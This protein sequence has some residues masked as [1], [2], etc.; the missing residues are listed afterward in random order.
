MRRACRER[1]SRHRIQRK[2]LVSDPGMHHGTCVTHVPW[3]MSGSLTRGGGE[4]VPGIPGNSKF[5]VSDKRPM[6]THV[7][8]LVN[9]YQSIW[10][11]KKWFRCTTKKASKPGVTDLAPM[12]LTHRGGDKMDVIFKCNDSLQTHIDGLVQDCSNSGALAMGL[13]QFCAKPSIYGSLGINELIRKG[14]KRVY[15]HTEGL[16]RPFFSAPTA[17]ETYV[18]RWHR[19]ISMQ[20]LNTD[21]GW[22]SGYL[23]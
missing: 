19:F 12:P 22:G 16:F 5:Y 7:L 1:F 15:N 3:C 13:M 11:E 8:E 20:Y 4:N 14:Y 6:T 17:L 23:A 2:P 18:H 9:I 21:Q 10:F